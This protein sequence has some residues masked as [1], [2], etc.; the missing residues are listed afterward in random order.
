[1]IDL[2]NLTKRYGERTVVDG[3]TFTVRPGAVTGF[4]GPNGAG[5]STTMRMM[6]GL[7]RPDEGMTRFDGRAYPELRR[8]ARHVGALLETAIPHRSLT[9]ADHLRWM[10]QCNRIPRQRVGEVLDLVG[11]AGA[12]RRR[13]GTY[14][15]GMGQRLG[16]AAA[17]L[18]DPPVL[19]LD[20]PVNGLDAEGIRWLRELLRAKAAEG[21][22]VLVSSHLMTEMSLV[23]DHLVVIDRGRLLADTGMDEFIRLH[24][25]M[26]VRVRTLEPGALVPELERHGA[27]VVR[28]VDGSLEVD[29]LAAAEVSRIATAGGRTLDELSTHTGSLED[30]FLALVGK[31]N[32]GHR[33]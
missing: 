1:M 11:L 12:A 10:A 18:G 19:V 22:T 30:T 8:P 27:R 33:V 2:Q 16:L 29:G 23:A 15:L 26:Y 24:G 13:V 9:A 25:R 7:T 3:L 17:L 32:G 14:S 5:K 31:E 20:E 28:A 21:R 6:L 4:L